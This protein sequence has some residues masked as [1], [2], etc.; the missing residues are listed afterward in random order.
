MRALKKSAQIRVSPQ[1][2]SRF[3]L[4]L[5]TRDPLV[6]RC[7]TCGA[8]WRPMRLPLSGKNNNEWL[9]ANGC[10]QSRA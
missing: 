9:C 8:E 5:V 4:E 2:L 1:Q 3:G 7:P 6:V 10:R